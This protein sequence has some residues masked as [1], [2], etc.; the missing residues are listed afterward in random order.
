MPLITL[1]GLE[2]GEGAGSPPAVMAPFVAEEEAAM[3]CAP[4]MVMIV[5]MMMMMV[6]VW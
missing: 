2:R 3:P 5:M 6:T 1:V 4:M